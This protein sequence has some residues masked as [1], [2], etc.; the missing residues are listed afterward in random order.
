MR[1]AVQ[2]AGEGLGKG[3]NQKQ[4][5]VGDISRILAP[6]TLMVRASEKGPEVVAEDLYNVPPGLIAPVAKKRRMLAGKDKSKKTPTVSL[7]FNELWKKG[8]F[9]MID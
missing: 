2:C 6:A 1:T 3:Y 9:Y 7:I 4:C 8:S 5:G